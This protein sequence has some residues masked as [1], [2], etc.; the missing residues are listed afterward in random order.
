M[1]AR[2]PREVHF[3][4][5]RNAALRDLAEAVATYYHL[6]NE[7]GVPALDATALASALQDSLVAIAF[8]DFSPDP[9]E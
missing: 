9:Q 2:T 3:E 1:T 4:E 7:N 6:L 8:D 5:Q